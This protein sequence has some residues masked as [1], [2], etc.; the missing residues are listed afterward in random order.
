MYTSFYQQKMRLQ[1]RLYLIHNIDI[2][3]TCSDKALKGTVLNQ[4][5]LSLNRMSLKITL[6][7]PLRVSRWLSMMRL[8]RRLYGIDKIRGFSFTITRRKKPKRVT[9]M[10]SVC[11]C[12]RKTPKSLKKTTS[13]VLSVMLSIYVPTF[14][15]YSRSL[16]RMPHSAAFCFASWLILDNKICIIGE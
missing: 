11:Y 16:R 3:H 12:E 9:R 7:I 13:S 8:Q 10:L 14:L 1:K 4:T 15:L 2:F 5:L 6:A